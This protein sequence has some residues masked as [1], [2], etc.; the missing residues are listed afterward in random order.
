MPAT[1]ET[2]TDPPPPLALFWLMPLYFFC[3]RRGM[4]LP[5]IRFV[6]DEALPEPQRSLLVHERDMTPVLAAHHGSPLQLE[7]LDLERGR[8]HLLRLVNLRRQDNRQAVECGA[9]AIYLSRFSPEVRAL[10]EQGEIPL[11][12]ILQQENVPHQGQP[13]GF[14]E[15]RADSLFAHALGERK[16][17]ILHGRCN[18]LSFPDGESFADVVEILP[19][20][21]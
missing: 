10:I 16:G 3:E 21:C 6:P 5:P 20:R 15:I 4:E 13:R 7:V 11:G 9:I 8:N 18:E 2:A 1:P 12:A 19:V 17:A 14:F